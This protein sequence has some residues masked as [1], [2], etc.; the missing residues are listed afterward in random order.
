M[1]KCKDLTSYPN[2][3][4]FIHPSES[5]FVGMQDI[6]YD[7]HVIINNVRYFEGIHTEEEQDAHSI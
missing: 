4:H 3:D 2:M 6:N 7:L 1:R 5:I